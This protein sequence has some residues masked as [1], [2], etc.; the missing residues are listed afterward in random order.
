[1]EI[2][3]ILPEL[4]V[5]PCP[6][7]IEDIDHLRREH[8]ITAVLNLQTDDDIEQIEYDWKFLQ[9]YYRQSRIALRRVPVHD[10]DQN[11]LRKNLPICVQSLNELL[12][13]DHIVYVHCTLGVGRAPSVVVTYLHWI[14]QWDLELALRHVSAR[15]RCSPN[16]EAIR[17]ASE[18][19][20]VD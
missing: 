18:D 9:K 19:L 6:V 4:F 11:D 8:G 16:L 10:F 15:R 12:R 1:M 17:L 13:D 3:E 7:R 5:G 14:Q 2:S 20:L